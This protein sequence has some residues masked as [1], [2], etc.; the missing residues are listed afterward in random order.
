MVSR[1]SK[2]IG[3]SL[4]LVV[5]AISITFS[6]FFLDYK[7]I[8]FV[9]SLIFNNTREFTYEWQ[10]NPLVRASNFAMGMLFGIF[11]INAL[12]KIESEDAR[13][14]EY[15]ISKVVKRSKPAQAI[16]QIVGVILMNVAF[17]LIVPV[18]SDDVSVGLV[19][20]FLAGC[21]AIFLFGL[22][23]FIFPSVIGADSWLTRFINKLLGN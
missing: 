9:P 15:K 11:F 4:L 2:F 19:K 16:I 7:K 23:L 12:E 3:Y 5:I 14:N 13:T 21:P 22:G 6:A 18:S 17:W 8:E 1:S 10:M 20:F